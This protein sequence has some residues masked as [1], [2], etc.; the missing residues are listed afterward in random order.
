MLAKLR[1]ASRNIVYMG[2]DHPDSLV[3]NAPSAGMNSG[4]RINSFGRAYGSGRSKSTLTALKMAVVA[5][6]PIASVSTDTTVNA[7]RRASPR[8]AYRISCTTLSTTS[9]TCM[10]RS[11]WLAEVCSRRRTSASDAPSRR[12]ASRRASSGVIPRATR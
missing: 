10:R 9:L 5:P 7:G 6:T 2:Y 8:A 12:A 3:A 4:T 11:R 1:C